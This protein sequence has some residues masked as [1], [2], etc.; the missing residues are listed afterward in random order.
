M[1]TA[2]EWV[3]YSMANR[4]RKLAIFLAIG[5][6]FFGATL[7]VT[8]NI[9]QAA[10]GISPPFMNPTNLLPG[11]SYTQTIYLVQDQ[12]DQDLRIVTKL[13]IPA[14]IRP[15]ITMNPGLQFTIPQGV[16]QFPV[17]IAV[18]VPKDTPLG[19]Y[20]GNIL[21]IAAPTGEGQV[22]IAL[23]AEVA[24][25]LTVGNDIVRKLTIPIIRPL[26][27]E[28]GWDPRA[29]VKVV[30]E[31]NVAERFSG[32]TFE[33]MDQFGASRLAYIQKQ[34]GFPEIPAF[35][36]QEFTLEFPT[37]FYLGIGQYWASITLFREDRVEASNRTVFNALKRGSLSTLT[38]QILRH[39]KGQWPYYA[40]GA[41]V[42]GIA[43]ALMVRRRKHT[44]R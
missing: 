32:A 43:G 18:Q 42:L 12:P 22:A 14:N 40:G 27:I 24:I 10:F 9:A 39:L 3:L 15:W 17:E 31:G 4:A 37:N 29:Y 25:N 5:G 36:T 41:V 28:E 30:N 23:G 2:L 35:S 20:S 16:R 33:L 7:L 38:E 34:D 21:F 13:D 8:P 11:S 19:V 1:G 6:S 44:R 26:D